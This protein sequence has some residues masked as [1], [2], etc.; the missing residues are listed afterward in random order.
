MSMT[1][2]AKASWALLWTECDDQGVF[3][4]KPVVLKARILPAD[5]V[6]FDEILQEYLS[7]GVVMSFTVGG[8]QYGTIKNFRKYQRPK[9]PNKV[10]PNTP[11][12]ETFACLPD[13]SSE[14]VG[15]QTGTAPE[16]SK[17]RE[18]EGG[19]MEDIETSVSKEDKAASTATP[20]LV[21]Q[22]FEYFCQTMQGSNISIPR[23]LTADRRRNLKARISEHGEQVV[24][25]AMRKLRDSDFCNGSNDRGW[26]A[27]LDFLCQPKSFNRLIEGGYDN[28]TQHG[29]GSDESDLQ[30]LS[31][32]SKQ[33]LREGAM[34]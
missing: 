28:R 3:E 22:A 23:K 31:R 16:K 34:Q 11:E 19:R 5:N 10:H 6:N 4:W 18:D 14:Q 8:K 2:Y 12:S 21:D 29:G 32:M 1:A 17:Q 30:R 15:N 13:E 24:A 25:E 9:K 27:D 26:T 20:S 33:M 7:L